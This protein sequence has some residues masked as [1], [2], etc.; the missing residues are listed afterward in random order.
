MSPC[1]DYE[2]SGPSH[3]CGHYGCETIIS[4][5]RYC[6][7]HSWDW[8]EG[9]CFGCGHWFEG[10]PRAMKCP[11]CRRQIRGTP[12]RTERDVTA[13]ECGNPKW[14][15]PIDKDCPVCGDTKPRSRK[16]L[17]PAQ[18]KHG[19]DGHAKQHVGE[20]GII[21]RGGYTFE[22]R[23]FALK[24]APDKTVDY[25]LRQYNRTKPTKEQWYMESD[26]V[27]ADLY[28]DGLSAGTTEDLLDFAA[29]YREVCLQTLVVTLGS[30]P[31][32]LYPAGN[33]LTMRTEQWYRWWNPEFCFLARK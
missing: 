21:Q 24:T 27:I 22:D 4:D 9:R 6:S 5:E 29:Q 3:W 18:H 17:G 1:G 10:E 13:H 19:P 16:N 28:Q 30:G 25:I 20:P 23:V 8:D 15:M 32:L 33:R 2:R 26:H 11:K 31:R 14:Y 12:P 7:S